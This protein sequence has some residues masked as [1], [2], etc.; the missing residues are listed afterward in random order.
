MTLVAVSTTTTVLGSGPRSGIVAVSEGMIC[1]VQLAVSVQFDP[2]P[3]PVHVALWLLTHTPPLVSITVA[4]GNWDCSPSSTPPASTQMF[5]MLGK[6]PEMVTVLL[7]TM[8]FLPYVEFWPARSN[9]PPTGASPSSVS[10]SPSPLMSPH[11]FIV[12]PSSHVTRA[13]DATFRSG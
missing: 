7:V 4:S 8:S 1:G 2:S 6:L 13:A 3:A 9:V 10:V 5:V 11:S 12:K